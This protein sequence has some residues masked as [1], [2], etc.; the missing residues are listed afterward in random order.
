MTAPDPVAALRA[1]LPAIQRLV[2][3]NTG[4]AGPLPTP[5]HGAMVE[6][7]DTDL[8]RG[9]ATGRRFRLLAE[10]RDA[11]REA[12]ATLLGVRP[13]QCTL[14][15][16]TVDGIRR[17]AGAAD[18]A[19]GDVVVTTSME[20]PEVLA[21]LRELAAE[22]A[23]RLL[24]VDLD[25]V[26]PADVP[27]AVAVRL[28]DRIRLAVVSHVAYATGS[29]LP[30]T[31]LG[32]LVRGRGG[33]L[34]V[35]GAQA[36]GALA[37]DVAAS[38]ADFYALPGQKWLCGPEGT[39]VLV[40]R[41]PTPALDIRLPSGVQVAGLLAALAWRASY[42]EAWLARRVADGAARLH[43][44]L[45]AVPGITVLTPDR[46]AG[47]VSVR[48]AGHPSVEVARQLGAAGVLTRDVA[49]VDATRLCVA[50]FTTTE[51]ITSVTRILTDLASTGARR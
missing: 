11:L 18:I 31:D 23:A 36:A 10:R 46:H 27:D 48:V 9:R 30:V 50:P 14:T 32:D 4:T 38:G 22:R 17:A 40:S 25:G 21:F 13:E 47:L 51:E 28:P 43:A 24:V 19:T 1:D 16:G 34:I 12:L 29:L 2:Y 15:A 20:H 49:A 39:G 8:A 44:G 35:D 6:A 33:V 41:D 26:G 37:V 42:G 5:V 7:L 3:L 45:A